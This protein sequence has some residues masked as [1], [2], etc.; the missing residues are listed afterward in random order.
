MSSILRALHNL[1]VPEH[2]SNESNVILLVKIKLLDGSY[3]EERVIVKERQISDVCDRF[4]HA[5]DAQEVWVYRQFYHR[6]KEPPKADD[7]LADAAILAGGAFAGAK[8]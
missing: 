6:L 1:V 4:A 3:E 7:D 5:E 8:L 2:G